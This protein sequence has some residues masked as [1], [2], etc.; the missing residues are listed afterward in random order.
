MGKLQFRLMTLVLLLHISQFT[1][2][3]FFFQGL[4]GI[5]RENGVPLEKLSL[6]YILGLFMIFRFLWAPFLD[7]VKFGRLGHYKV[8]LMICQIF[9]IVT[10]SLISISNVKSG[11]N[12]IF[13]LCM[14]FAFFAATQD[15]A[16]DALVYK[17]C[18]TKELINMASSLKTSGMYLGGII[19][20][21]LI[22]ILY[23]NF[24]W[25]MAIS[26]LMCLN[27]IPLIF[28]LNFQEPIVE[29]SKEKGGFIITQFI[30]FWK[31]KRRLKWLML[32]LLTPLQ[33]SLA[34]GI[35]NPMLVDRGFS[36]T[37]IGILISFI[38]GMG[39]ALSAFLSTPIINRFGKKKVLVFGSILEGL[40]ILFLLVIITTDANLYLSGV[41]VF[42]AIFLFSPIYVVILSYILEEIEEKSH[43]GSQYAIQHCVYMS[44][45]LLGA[46]VGMSLAGY[47]GYK[48]VII[49]AFTISLIVSYLA[50]KKSDTP[51]KQ[52]RS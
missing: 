46:S 6:L 22:L 42:M 44:C 21:G 31:G 25:F 14:M 11:F 23:D 15:I 29:Y 5:F 33:I 35:L 43:I 50:Y 4:M 36:L 34:Y 18:T 49:T 38:G 10:L 17:V 28:V 30:R 47:L 52:I 40:A 41:I 39:G 27:L 1:V 3:G 45:D 26:F 48:Y 19:G 8:W 7:K 37:A 16:I 32:L 24:S 9:I 20:G 13:I 51:I 12:V 2:L